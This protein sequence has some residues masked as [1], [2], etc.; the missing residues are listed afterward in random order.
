VAPTQ[1]SDART[2][3]GCKRGGRKPAQNPHD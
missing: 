2:A 1:L 3:F